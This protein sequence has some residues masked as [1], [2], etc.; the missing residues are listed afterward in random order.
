MR[1]LQS[2]VISDEQGTK[3]RRQKGLPEEQGEGAGKVKPIKTEV[4][5]CETESGASK[6]AY[7]M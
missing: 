3:K 4:V 2:F 1:K 6:I 7:R 5:R